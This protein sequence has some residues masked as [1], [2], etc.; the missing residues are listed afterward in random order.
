MATVNVLAVLLPQPLFAFTEM[1]PPVVPAVTVIELV[2][3]VPVQPEGN[4]H[5]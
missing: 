2:V 5:V 3:D 1:V 4:V